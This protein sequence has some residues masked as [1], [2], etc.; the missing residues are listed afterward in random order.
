MALAPLKPNPTQ[1]KNKAEILASRLQ[2]WNLL[3]ENVRVTPFHTRHLLF[4]SFFKKE[5]SIVFCCDI[6]GLLKELHIAHEPNEW[7]LFIDVLKLSLKAVLL[8][9]GN[10]LPS[11]PVA[12]AVYMKEIYHNL[13]Q[14]LDMINYSKYDWQICAD[15]KV[16][17][18][19]MGLQLGYTKYCCFLCLWGSRAIA[20]HYIKRDSPQ[21]AS[22]KPGEVNVKHPLLAEPHKVSIP[23]LHI[24]LGL[25][26]NLVKAMD[27][28]GPAFKYLHEKFPRLSVAKIK[29]DV[30]V[31]T[32]IKQLF[33]YSKFETS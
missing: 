11:I 8:N 32:Q 2:Q 19:L 28:N 9:N 24:K 29:E 16:M 6:H 3:E 5:E 30:F 25:V 10:E 14:L 17:S 13:K 15:L 4:E 21:R 22:F 18:L 1:P 26:K 31:G 27:K 12:H 23:P 20:L 33:R 7:R